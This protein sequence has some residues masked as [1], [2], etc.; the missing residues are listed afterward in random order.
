ME[1]IGRVVNNDLAKDKVLQKDISML[2]N[3]KAENIMFIPIFA[4]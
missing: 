1:R 2:F 3:I 4:N